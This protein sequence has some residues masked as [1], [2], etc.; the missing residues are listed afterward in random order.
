MREKQTQLAWVTMS[1]IVSAQLPR[2]DV[3]MA[4]HVADITSHKMTVVLTRLL[5]NTRLTYTPMYLA[6]G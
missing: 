5:S 4:F 1:Q 3:V 2:F 6:L